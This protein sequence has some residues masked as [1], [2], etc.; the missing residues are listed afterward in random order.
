MELTAFRAIFDENCPPL[1]SVKGALGHTLGAAG[2]IETAL[3]LRSLETGILPPTVGLDEPEPVA[4]DRVS[5]AARS[6]G[7]RVLLS[8]N[9]GFGGINGAL[10][11]GREEVA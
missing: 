2:G 4:G 9:S 11:L 5:A 7:G 10:L 8:T 1:H 3:G 6:F